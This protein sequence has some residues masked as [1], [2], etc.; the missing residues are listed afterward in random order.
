MA[1]G[2]AA[3][4]AAQALTGPRAGLTAS[5]MLHLTVAAAYALL[6][7]PVVRG[8]VGRVRD[9]LARPVAD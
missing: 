5:G 6:L 4:A 3:V 1:A 2:V 8:P 7:I 9:L